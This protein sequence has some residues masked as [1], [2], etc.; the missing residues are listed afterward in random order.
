MGPESFI[1]LS[2]TA[3]QSDAEGGKHGEKSDLFVPGAATGPDEWKSVVRGSFEA[4]L[5]EV[6]DRVGVTKEEYRQ[7]VEFGTI[8]YNT[9]KEKG[10]L[11]A[12]RGRLCDQVRSQRAGLRQLGVPVGHRGQHRHRGR[13]QHLRGE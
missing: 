8:A 11:E 2:K 13:R 1:E 12:G 7:A 5:S 10:G 6:L 4:G 9:V 3:F